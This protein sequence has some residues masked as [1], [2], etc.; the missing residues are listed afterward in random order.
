MKIQ[1]LQKNEFSS[2]INAL[3]LEGW[4][5][6]ITYIECLFKNFTKDFFVVYYENKIIGFISAI[7]YSD[8]F[9]FISNFV[10]LKQFRS[11]GF[12]K[13]LF[14]HALEHLKDCQIALESEIKDENIYVKYDF[15]SYYDTLY[16]SFKI[17]NKNIFPTKLEIKNHIDKN[18]IPIYLDCVVLDKKT[19][20]KAIY[21]DKK[22]SSYGLCTP[23]VDGYKVFISSKNDEEAMVIFFALIQSF[24]LFTVIYI[25]VTKLDKALI[26]I[27]ELLDMKIYSKKRRMYNKLLT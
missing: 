16:Y 17:K 25:E 7:R 19:I 9:G 4:Y 24:K 18:Q 21:H 11:L 5:V 12:G 15:K 10:V 8:N 2:L 6:E 23:Y 20:T 1:Q 14:C 3:E 22:L 13:K 27:V 26:K